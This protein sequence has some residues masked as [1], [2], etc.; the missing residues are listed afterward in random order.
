MAKLFNSNIIFQAITTALA[1]SC[2]IAVN[3]SHAAEGSAF[4]TLPEASGGEC[5]AKVNVPAVYKSETISAVTREASEKISIT[6]AKY[7]DATERVMIKE[8][9]TK[10]VPVD[11]VYEDEEEKVLISPSYRMWVRG[12]LKSKVPASKGIL[13]DIADSGVD[14]DNVP[15]G[16]C[17]YEY[18]K[19]AQFKDIDDRI[20]VSEATEKLVVVPAKFTPS[21]KRVMT[22][23]AAKRLKV[24]PTEYETVTEKVLVE[25]AHK[26]WKKGRGPIERI[27]NSTGE[28]MCLINVPARYE[29][30][31]RQVVKTAARAESSSIPAVFDSIE[32]EKLSQDATESRIPVPAK[33]ES[34]I[35]RTKVS[36]AVLTWLGTEKADKSENGE[37]TGNVVC[38]SE[39]PAEYKTYT[40]KVVKTAGSFRKVTVPAEYKTVNV[41]KLAANASEQR[42]VIPEKKEELIKRV[43]VSDARLEW[44][45]VLCETNLTKNVVSEIQR[46]LNTK[47][48]KAGAVDGVLGRGTMDALEKFQKDKNLARGGLTYPTISALGVDL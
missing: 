33:Y 15:V 17:Y 27:D 30:I 36:D 14:L 39:I 48:Y 26:E 44:R 12:S 9:S 21:T 24:L 29:E 10:L 1:T 18:H 35:R 43:K 32:I 34:Y 28:I 20:M 11:A 31:K 19:P 41:K 6:P 2:L 4:N 22:K 3:T 40:R 38:H 5:Y 13:A 7:V 25:P 42:T 16:R 8:A 47:G 46:A 45:P 37:L 23:A